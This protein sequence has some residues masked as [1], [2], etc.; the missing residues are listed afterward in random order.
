VVCLAAIPAVIEQ[1]AS[2][3]GDHAVLNIFAGVSRGTIVKLDIKDVV[4]K[5]A[6]YIGSSGSSLEDMVYTLRRVEKNGLD[7]NNAVAGVSGMNDVWNGID[8][9]RTGSFP[10]K[11]VVYPHIRKL[12]LTS[13]DELAVRYPRIGALLTESGGWTREAEQK[14][15]DELLDI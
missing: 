14:L 10:G 13:L 1:S 2:Y 7:T 8:A 15:L 3:L 5:S 9:V 6:R 12:E 4:A 11:I